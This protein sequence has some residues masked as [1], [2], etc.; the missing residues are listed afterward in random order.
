MHE[1][2]IDVCFAIVVGLLLTVAALD[3]FDILVK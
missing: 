1:T 3:Y 2:L